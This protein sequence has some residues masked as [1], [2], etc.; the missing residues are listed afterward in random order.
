MKSLHAWTL[1]AV[2]ALPVLSAQAESPTRAFET[3]AREQGSIALGANLA[4]QS[5][6]MAV[7]ETLAALDAARA[8]Y[9]PE[10]ALNARYTRA[11]GGRQINF[12]IGALLNPAYQTL[13]QL[14]A[15][16][17][18]APRFPTITDQ[19][20]EFQRPREQDTRV[21]L[22]QP[23]YQPA[24]PAA[25]A[26]QR[27]LLGGQRFAR[28]AFARQLVRDVTVGYAQYLKARRATSI[29]QSA[30]SLL[31]ENQRVTDSLFRNGRITQDQ[32]LRARAERL[33]AEQQLRESE[34]AATQA[35]AYVN[36]LL[37]RPQDTP[38]E[39][40]DLPL[41]GD[42]DTDLR[43]A[44]D[45]AVRQRPELAQLDALGRAA[46][47][48]QRIARAALGPQLALGVDA[49]TQGEQYRLGSGYNYIAASVVLSWKLFDGGASRAEA[50]KSRLVARDL[51]LKRDDA[52]QRVQL[53]VQQAVDRLRTAHDSLATARAREDAAG[54]AFRIATRKRDEGAISQVEF[55][56][57]RN[58]LTAAQ[59]NLNLTRF[60]LAARR[61]ELDHATGGAELPPAR[62]DTEGLP[63]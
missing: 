44:R 27:E 42:G 52:L 41:E 38:L 55:L 56:D 6:D 14:L 25:V 50:A 37:N 46:D 1:A 18:Q 4:L 29:V 28:E 48:Q 22:R 53:E 13:N 35:A 45:S 12:P 26:A 24:I 9:F 58:T 15:A 2:L 31:D 17:G 43:S 11:E 36:F 51:R 63:R 33:A 19:A 30:L 10:F 57:A 34:S 49:G 60:E 5:Q 59:L 8:R 3:V 20:F 47:A 39:D 16:Q 40:A 21:T 54:A 61:A 7:E 23:L 32:V 62:P